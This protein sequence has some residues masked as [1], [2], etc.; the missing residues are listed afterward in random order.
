MAIIR[1]TSIASLGFVIPAVVKCLILE[2]VT[3]NFQITVYHREINV[4]HLNTILVL[5]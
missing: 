2:N 1:P 3:F 4:Y 5:R